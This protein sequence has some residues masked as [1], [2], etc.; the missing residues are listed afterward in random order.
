MAET[1][2]LPRDPVIEAYKKDVDRTLIRENLRRTPEERLRNLFALQR[3][4]EELRRAGRSRRL[5][6]IST[7][8]GRSQGEEAPTRIFCVQEL[9]KV[10]RHRQ[11][12][13]LTRAD[14][15]CPGG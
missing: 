10:L 6:A 15:Q 14:R 8:S 3:A 12:L 2:D 11:S 1:D 9:G 4:A 5:S 13:G 7:C